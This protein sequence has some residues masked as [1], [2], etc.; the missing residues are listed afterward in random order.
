MDVSS[1][2]PMLH[3]PICPCP[4]VKACPRIGYGHA[5]L[6]GALK[7]DTGLLLYNS[8]RDPLSQLNCA[9]PDTTQ[10]GQPHMLRPLYLNATVHTQ[11]LYSMPVEGGEGMN[12]LQ[13]MKAVQGNNVQH[14][15]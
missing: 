1:Q 8:L 7:G 2:P 4:W 10:L 6:L 9:P 15:T 14:R 11:I 5:L 13:S 3:I 12:S